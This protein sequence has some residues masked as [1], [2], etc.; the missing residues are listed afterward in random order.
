MQGLHFFRCDILSIT[1][2][3][4]RFDFI[5]I[6]RERVKVGISLFPLVTFAGLGVRGRL[7]LALGFQQQ[8][9]HLGLELMAL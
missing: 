6:I 3:V 2:L 9:F 8:P 7:Q 4:E 5:A 1:L